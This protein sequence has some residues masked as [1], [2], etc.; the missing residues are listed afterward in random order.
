M[1][2]DERQSSDGQSAARVRARTAL[3]RQDEL[4]DPR[5][6]QSGQVHRKPEDTSRGCRAR[7]EADNAEAAE[8]LSGQMRLRL[9]NSAECWSA[10]ARLLDRLESGREKG[11]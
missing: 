10:R 11:L 6:S 9:E 2:K 1:T 7:A 5:G 3:D 4:R 8:S